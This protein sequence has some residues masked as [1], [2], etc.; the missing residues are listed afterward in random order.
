MSRLIEDRAW[1]GRLAKTT[2]LVL[3]F[4][5]AA[6]AL[7]PSKA[8]AM[9]IQEVKSPGGITA[10]LVEE[11]S[12][13]LIA[14]RFAFDGGSSQDPVG[15]DGLANFLSGM[16][17]EG[18]GNLTSKQ[19]QERM[20]EIAM[21]MSF[22]D[23]RDAF[24]GS[25]E[26][27]TQ[28]RD[29][30][31][32]LLT[33]AIN[34]PRF[35]AEAVERMRGQYL[36]GLVA[37]ARDPTRV[38]AE[39]WM[40]LAFAGHPYGR[41][42][43]GTPQSVA[44]ITRD[45]LVAFRA[46]TFAKDNLRVVAVGDID[47]AALGVM[48]DTIFGALPAKAKLTPVANTE[49]KAAQRLKVI[50]MNVPQSVARFGLPALAR[51][52]K[53]FMASFILNT[54]FGGGFTSRLYN[55]VREKRGLA[56]GVDSSIIPLKNASVFIG[57]VA[58]KN[59]KIG[60]SLEVIRSELRRI[61]TDGVTAEELNDAKSYLTGS[62]ALRFD[63]NA[64]IANQLLWMMVEGL[65]TSYVDTRNAQIDA[66]TLDDIKRVAKR[67][68]DGQEPIVTVVGKPKGVAPTAQGGG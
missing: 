9:K 15:K 35:D 1:A 18:A 5:A 44:G 16:L 33:L 48:L 67:L 36:A 14:V 64:N 57:N 8:S 25:F 23:G 13:P 32:E 66:V 55:E 20:E 50:D 49:P 30:A 61:A 29:G 45:D 27:L 41:P 19:F 63:T 65:G 12:V 4:A 21:R 3:A 52:D 62:F 2:W 53:D 54:I 58:T 42:P 24:Y 47:A 6:L 46:R 51:K 22:E 7:T 11:H 34:R 39:Q 60:Q 10:W 43:N 59:E 68:F 28:N 37:A 40:A 26:T 38:S 17:D 31:V 56:Y